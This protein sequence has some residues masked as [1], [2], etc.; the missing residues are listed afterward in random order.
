[1]N[2]N[3]KVNI[4]YASWSDTGKHTGITYQMIILN[5]KSNIY[6]H[7]TD[8]GK[9]ENNIRANTHKKWRDFGTESTSGLHC[10][11][12]TDLWI[13]PWVRFQIDSVSVP[14]RTGI[15]VSCYRVWIARTS[16]KRYNTQPNTQRGRAINT[17]PYTL[18][19]VPY[20]HATRAYTQGTPTCMY[21]YGY[22][23]TYSLYI[24]IHYYI[25]TYKSIY[26]YIRTNLYIPMHAH[27]TAPY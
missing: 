18:R 16:L 24:H 23:H 1:M 9:W 20:T 26:I 15:R 17:H 11:N 14:W 4:H 25:H 27:T 21:I 5:K 22:T 2:N 19:H 6:T 8:N 7:T 13:I 12:D 3:A 10:T